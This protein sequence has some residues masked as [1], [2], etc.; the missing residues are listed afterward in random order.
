MEPG[1]L[2]MNKVSITRNL[3]LVLLVGVV[4]ACINFATA[5]VT[6]AGT[7]ETPGSEWNGDH[8]GVNVSIAALPLSFMP[9]VG[10]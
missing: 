8:G 4:V 3:F 7:S 9:N 6:V 1:G 2:L 5:D 10:I